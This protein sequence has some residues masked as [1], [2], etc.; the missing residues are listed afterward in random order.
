LG[1]IIFFIALL[2]IIAIILAVT[3]LSPNLIWFSLF[4]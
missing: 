1:V 4:F 3:V 2:I